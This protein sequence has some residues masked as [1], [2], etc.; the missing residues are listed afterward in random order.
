[1]DKKTL[2]EIS[3]AKVQSSNQ[4]QSSNAKTR[5]SYLTFGF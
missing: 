5:L 1:M 3:N 4:I 2:E